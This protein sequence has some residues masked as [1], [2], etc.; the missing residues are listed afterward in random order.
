MERIDIRGPTAGR[1]WAHRPAPRSPRAGWTPVLPCPSFSG[2]S[3]RSTGQGG[4]AARRRAWSIARVPRP[5]PTRPPSPAPE[6]SEPP[7]RATPAGTATSAAAHQSRHG[8]PRPR[9]GGLSC[10]PVLLGL[11]VDSSIEHDPK[12]GVCQLWITLLRFGVPTAPATAAVPAV[13]GPRPGTW[14][15]VGA[16]EDA[17]VADQ[18]EAHLV[19]GHDAPALVHGR[20]LG[21]RPHRKDRGLR[22]VDDR[23]EFA[24]SRTCRGSRP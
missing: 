23:R 13:R 3:P 11:W 10:S 22:R 17:V 1:C 7:A 8:T 9:R 4:P 5:R 2:Q 20:P 6:P 19:A 12:R 14:R 18:R 24:R 15:A 16:V 21:Q